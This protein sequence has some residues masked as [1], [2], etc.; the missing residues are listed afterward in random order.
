[1]D[2]IDALQ[3]PAAPDAQALAAALRAPEAVIR[4]WAAVAALR[5]ETLPDLAPLLGDPETVVRLAAAEAL[6]RRGENANAWN[7]IEAALKDPEKSE[8]RLFA[9]NVVARIPRHAP[10]GVNNMIASLAKT[11]AANGAENYTARAA[12]AVMR[13]TL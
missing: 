13:S 9:V 10:V 7:V 12:E 4:Y 2:T 5:A 3:Q 8:G 11:S 1:L 6:L